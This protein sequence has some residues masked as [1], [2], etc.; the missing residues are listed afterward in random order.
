MDAMLDMREKG[1][2]IYGRRRPRSTRRERKYGK[3][4]VKR[5]L[6]FDVTPQP[7]S[8]PE[9]NTSTSSHP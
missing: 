2:G 8:V 1:L 7:N 4:P 3:T 6:A 5:V 9:V